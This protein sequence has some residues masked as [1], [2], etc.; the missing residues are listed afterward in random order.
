[1]K[2]KPS[3]LKTCIFLGSSQKDISGF[4]EDV[5]RAFGHALH[6]VQ[7]GL[8]PYSAKALK[9]FGGRGVLEL[10]E[11]YDGST[12][13]AVYTLRFQAVVYVLHCFQK[14]VNEGHRDAPA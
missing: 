9:G 14:K 6:E 13:R 3:V 11:N 1:V 2:L 4:P 7:C 12:Y 10:V 5:R 8:E